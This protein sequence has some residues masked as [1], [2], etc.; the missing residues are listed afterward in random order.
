MAKE[1]PHSINATTAEHGHHSL[2]TRH[3]ATEAP[4]MASASKKR[5]FSQDGP[6]EEETHAQPLLAP[7]R[8]PFPDKARFS[9]SVRNQELLELY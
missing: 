3:P 5:K 1:E 4:A 7:W 2:V 9:L 8:I 6:A